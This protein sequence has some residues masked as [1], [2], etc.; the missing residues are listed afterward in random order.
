MGAMG[1]RFYGC[2]G[3]E[4]FYGCGGCEGC[5]GIIKMMTHSLENLTVDAFQPRVGSSFRIRQHPESAFE[6]ELI[7][8]R[9]LGDPGRSTAASGRRA[10][11]SLLFRTMPG[12][13][14]PQRIYQVEHDEMGSFDIFLVPVG[15]DAVGMVYEAV[16][17]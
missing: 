8:A 15:P 14:L 1:A 6:A 5:G 13:A 17:T 7:E 10:P 11:F 3:C 12:G 4:G 16:F 9:A 2:V